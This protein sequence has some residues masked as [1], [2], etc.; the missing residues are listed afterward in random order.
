MCIKANCILQSTWH[1]HCLIYGVLFLLFDQHEL[2]FLDLDALRLE[3]VSEPAD[4]LLEL[5]DELGVAVL[6]H[7]GLAH[8]LLRSKGNIKI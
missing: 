8:D 2:T 7:D 1:G 6:V 4:L 3:K 5:S